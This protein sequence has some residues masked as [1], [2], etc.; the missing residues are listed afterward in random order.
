MAQP[1]SSIFSFNT[2]KADIPANTAL[3]PPVKLIENHI[4]KPNLE[5]INQTKNKALIFN[6]SQ[7]QENVWYKR[8]VFVDYWTKRCRTNHKI[9][10]IRGSIDIYK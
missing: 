6:I 7:I 4:T 9:N 3:T 2:G 10:N 8:K 1:T 5:N